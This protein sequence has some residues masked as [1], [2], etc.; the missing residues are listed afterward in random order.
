MLSMLGHKADILRV[1]VKKKKNKK[2]MSQ[3]QQPQ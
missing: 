2:V 3:Q 1:E